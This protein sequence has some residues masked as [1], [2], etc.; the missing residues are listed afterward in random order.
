ML[1][2]ENLIVRV[3]KRRGRLEFAAPKVE[4]LWFLRPFGSKRDELE[5]TILL[6]TT[7]GTARTEPYRYEFCRVVTEVEHRSNGT[8]R[9]IRRSVRLQ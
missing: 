1:S 8:G 9:R 6:S 5:R 3:R 4:S 7:D 2:Y